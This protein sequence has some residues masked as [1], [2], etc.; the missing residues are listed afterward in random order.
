M[1]NNFGHS[2]NDANLVSKILFRKG[3]LYQDYS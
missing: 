3:K 2:E 1:Q